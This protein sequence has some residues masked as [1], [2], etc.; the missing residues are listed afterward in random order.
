VAGLAEIWPFV[1]ELFEADDLDRRMIDAGVLPSFEQVKAAWDGTVM[2][3]LERATLSV[4]EDDYAPTGG[5]S[6]RHTERLS[7]ILG[8]MQSVARSEPECPGRRVA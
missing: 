3:V 4:P 5:R 6:G 7:Y 1:H 2:P 8:E